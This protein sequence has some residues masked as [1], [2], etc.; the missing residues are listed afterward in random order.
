MTAG[1]PVSIDSCGKQYC[2]IDTGALVNLCRVELGTRRAIDWILN[3]FCVVIPGAIFDEG[4]HLVSPTDPDEHAHYFTVILALV[5]STN[6]TCEIIMDDQVSHLPPAERIK[7]DAGEKAAAAF[8]FEASRV[9]KQYVLFVTNDFSAS[10]PLKTIFS[11]VQL[12]ILRDA[13]DALEFI[14]SRHPEEI[15]PKALEIALRELNAM[16]RDPDLSLQE[17]SIPDQV[18]ARHLQ[19]LQKYPDVFAAI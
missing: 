9:H 13:Y 16:V 4:K 7:I 8:A 1:P 2:V 3:D 15:P 18:L 11:N 5:R 17:T 12:G 6:P 19:T 14:A 10:D